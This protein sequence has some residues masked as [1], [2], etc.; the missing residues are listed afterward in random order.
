M[1]RG[2]F[3]FCKERPNGAMPYSDETPA[4]IIL[5]RFNISKGAFKRALGKL[6]K[7]GLVDQEGSWTH[8][9]EKGRKAASADE[10]EE[11]Q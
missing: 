7:E 11:H 8:L 6:M 4:D 1:R 9:T 10:G 3:V 5:K 2:C